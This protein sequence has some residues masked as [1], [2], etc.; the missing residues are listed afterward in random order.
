MK[1]AGK[2]LTDGLS[3]GYAGNSVIKKVNRGSFNLESSHVEISGDVYHDEWAA[4]RVGGGQ[5]LVRTND[6]QIYAR[7]YGGGTIFLEELYKLG[8]K[9]KEV[10][11]YL[12]IKISSL[13]GKTRLDKDCIPKTDGDWKYLYEVISNEPKIPL[14]VG[15]EDIEYKKVKV[16]T[17]FFIICPVE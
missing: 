3:S 8:L 4:D 1:K 17:H 10:T 15:R 12:K 14:I 9:K 6:G 2:I 5:E 7:V 16:F 11:D 13:K